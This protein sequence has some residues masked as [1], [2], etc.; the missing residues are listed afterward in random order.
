MT[1]TNYTFTYEQGDKRKFDEVLQRLN[2]EEYNVVEKHKVVNPDDP[3]YSDLESV[4]E[5]DPEA[6]LTFRLGMKHLKIRRARTEE[7]LAEEAAQ[8]ERHKVK[9]TVKVDGL[10]PTP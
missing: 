4:I 8:D 2:E 9:I 6:A 5:M 1:W 7:E 3:R 10:P